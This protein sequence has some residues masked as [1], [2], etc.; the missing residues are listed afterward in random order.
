MLI[1]RR[2]LE[3]VRIM[4]IT[5]VPAS[6]KAGQATIEHLV[7]GNVRDLAVVGIYRNLTKVPDNLKAN[8]R[9]EARQGDVAAPETLDFA[10]SDVVI[11]VSPPQW[12]A[13]DGPVSAV[14]R[15][16]ENV[17]KAVRGSETVKRLVY[18]SSMGA[19]YEKGTVWSVH[20]AQKASPD[21]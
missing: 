4:K 15:L 10:G 17:E 18:V 16:A 13:P 9:F 5:V 12:S 3:S 14:K 11:T 21:H 8:P 1:L 20:Y 6:T 2:A 19:Q 7:A